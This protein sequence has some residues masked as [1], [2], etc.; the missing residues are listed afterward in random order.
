MLRRGVLV[1]WQDEIAAPET[2]GVELPPA[3]D[4]SPRLFAPSIAMD[5][6]RS[7]LG[8]AHL[9]VLPSSAARWQNRF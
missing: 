3:F 6:V 9:H 1:T 4:P 7:L 8:A 5:I 2:D